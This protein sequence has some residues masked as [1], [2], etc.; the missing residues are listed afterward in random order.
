MA[1]TA[2]WT[3]WTAVTIMTRVAGLICLSFASKS[4]PFMSGSMISRKTRSMGCLPEVAKGLS[5]VGG[6]MQFIIAF[7]DH[8]EGF[9]DNFLIIHNQDG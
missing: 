5:S 6:D 3:S 1:S 8:S 7:Q 9:P 4:I 2:V